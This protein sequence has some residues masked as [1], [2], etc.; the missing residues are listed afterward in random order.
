MVEFHD[1][2]ALL[3]GCKD[4]SAKVMAENIDLHCLLQEQGWLFVAQHHPVRHLEILVVGGEKRDGTTF[5]IDGV[6]SESCN[7]EEEIHFLR[8][9]GPP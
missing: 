6:A 5:R 4:M 3:R 7:V 2:W 1:L 8:W 9:L